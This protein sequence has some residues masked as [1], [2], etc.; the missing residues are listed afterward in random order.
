MKSH[1]AT[2]LAGLVLLSLFSFPLAKARGAETY[3]NFHTM[4]IVLDAPN[5]FT[6]AKIGQVKLYLLVG[7]KTRRLLDPVQVHDYSYY[8]VSVFDLKP[9]TEYKFRAEF[10]SSEGKVVHREEFAG[11]TRA[12]PGEPPTALK[13]IHVAATG[14]DANPGTAR[15]PKKTL[16]AA[17]RIANQAGTHVVIHKGIYYEGGL[18][19]VGKGT[20]EAPIVVRGASGESVTIDGSEPSSL[21][22]KWKDLGGGYFSIPYKATSWLVCVRNRKTGKTRRMYPVGSLANLKA[23]KVGRHAF[24]TVKIEEAYLCTGKEI[25]VYCPYY[26]PDEMSIHIAHHNS[27]AEHSASRHVVY[28]DLTVRFFQGQAFYVN[29][30]SDMTFR[31]CR[32]EYCT[33]PIA[34]KRTSHRLLVEYCRFLDDCTRWGFIPKD[35]DD[36]GYGKYLELGAVY[37]H[38]PYEG[39]GMVIRD[40]VI[41]GLFDGIH[42]T[43]MGPP[44]KVRTHETDFCNNRIVK[45]C[46]DLIEADG[47]CRNLRIF[48]NVMSNYLSG[49]SIAQGYHGPTYVVYNEITGAGNTSAVRLPP[50]HEGYPVKTNGG[51]RY[52]TTGWAFFYHNTSYTSVPKT[53]AFRVQVARWRKL[54]LA[55]NI[56]QGTRDGF[57]FW[58]DSVSPISMTNDIIH[59]DAG[60]LLKIRKKTYATKQA[61]QNRLPFFANAIVADPKLLDPGRGNFH[62]RSDSPAIDAGI[63]IPGINDH[64]FS[65]GAPDIGA[66]EYVSERN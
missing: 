45:V 39:R 7:D 24:D 3:G 20:A 19:A 27:V 44:S 60:S 31:R 12:E 4:G 37:V 57:V 33:L 54:V 46:D 14:D 47:Q 62:L 15:R 13:E 2:I 16:G 9:N 10:I 1:N 30:S 58:R 21:A 42:L 49:I 17:L 51:T 28:S 8:A 63:V 23:R 22:A 25:V 50:H 52:G 66:H 64:R 6:P 41:D 65:G 34:V 56:W 36:V 18:F 48:R 61:A 5:G 55:N 35:M 40:N 53:N 32:F 26:K 38:N 29:D 59:A 43:P 11:R